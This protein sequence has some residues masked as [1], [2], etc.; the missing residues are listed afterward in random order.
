MIGKKF[1]RLTVLERA[2]TRKGREYWWKCL[3]DCGRQIEVRGT[4]LRNGTTRSCGCLRNELT[5]QRNSTRADITNNLI[6]QKYGLLTATEL[7]PDRVNGQRVWRCQCECGKQKDVLAR[8][9]KTGRVKSCGCLPTNT[10]RDL[11]GNKYGRLTVIKLLPERKSNGGAVWLCRCDCGQELPV[12]AGNLLRGTTRSCGCLRRDDLS[13]QQFGR[14]TVESLG[15]KSGAGNGAY[16]LC[17]CVC[18]NYCEVQ[19]SKL[20]SGYTKSCG[21]IKSDNINNLVGKKFGKLTVVRDSGK[22]RGGS[23]GIIWECLCEC[24]ESKLMR[25][26]ALV[27]GRT[28]SCGCIRS[29]GNEKVA[30]L[31]KKHKIKY[32]KE[33]SPD[34]LKRKGSLRFDFAILDEKHFVVYF[35]EYDGELHYGYSNSGWDNAERFQRTVESDNLKNIYCQQHHI[36]LIRIPYTRYDKLDIADLVLAT[37]E[38]IIS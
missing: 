31:L 16:W 13:G 12:A 37:S 23:G 10:S 32:I 7:L 1:G 18:G 3:C 24:G 35:I 27:S 2:N 36:P 30:S 8:D 9:L 25:Q 15:S 29:K 19:A 20:K 4:S 5:R 22:R 26:D 11:T 33:Y 17:R 6:G 38:F 28:I 34:D 21:C 14:L